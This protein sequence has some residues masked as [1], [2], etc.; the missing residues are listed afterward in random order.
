MSNL[1]QEM[2]EII[3][4]IAQNGKLTVRLEARQAHSILNSLISQQIVTSTM[5]LLEEK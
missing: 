4:Y 3:F 5:E 2:T 1:I